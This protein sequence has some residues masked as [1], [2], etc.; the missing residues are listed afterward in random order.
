[1]IIALTTWWE[2][3]VIELS[4]SKKKCDESK[5]TAQDKNYINFYIMF[6]FLQFGQKSCT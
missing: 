6:G 5:N 4:D 2:I 1:M 3:F